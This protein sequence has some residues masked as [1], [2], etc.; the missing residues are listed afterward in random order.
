M[1]EDEQKNETTEEPQGEGPG[2]A[3]DQAPVLAEGAR[4]R[5]P[6]PLAERGG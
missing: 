5:A 4:R 1:S 3:A 2:A 6:R